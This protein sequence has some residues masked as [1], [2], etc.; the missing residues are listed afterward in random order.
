MVSASIHTHPHLH[1]ISIYH[2]HV[3][4]AFFFPF[5][6]F[7]VFLSRYYLH[8]WVVWISWE[9]GLGIGIDSVVVGFLG[10]VLFFPPSLLLGR[11]IL[12][13]CFTWQAGNPGSCTMRRVPFE[14]RKRELCDKKS[15]PSFCRAACSCGLLYL[16]LFGFCR[17]YHGAGV[18]RL[19][20]TDWYNCILHKKSLR[21]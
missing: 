8:S 16:S 19:A 7:W 18:V 6:F 10:V 4:T 12:S 14:S 15:G 9:S 21:C 11:F 3:T 13:F 17:R 2:D 5:L 20:G 1:E